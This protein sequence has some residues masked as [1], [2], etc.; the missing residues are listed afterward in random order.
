MSVASASKKANETNQIATNSSYFGASS[1]VETPIPEASP[2]IL[3]EPSSYL[4]ILNMHF[5]EDDELRLR[6]LIGS[7]KKNSDKN[8]LIVQ[9]FKQNRQLMM[10]RDFLRRC[11]SNKQLTQEKG[12]VDFLKFTH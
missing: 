12:E 11:I 8:E 1:G 7:I 3:A 9:L 4:D 10:E 5:S 2:P 6:N